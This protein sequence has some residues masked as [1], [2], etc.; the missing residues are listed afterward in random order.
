MGGGTSRSCASVIS[1]ESAERAIRIHP[2]RRPGRIGQVIHRATRPLDQ[3]AFAVKRLPVQRRFRVL[4]SGCIRGRCRRRPRH[5]RESRGVHQHHRVTPG[6]SGPTSR[7]RVHTARRLIRTTKRAN[8]DIHFLGHP[9]APRRVH[10]NRKCRRR[11]RP[12]TPHLDIA[13]QPTPAIIAR[14]N[15]AHTPHRI[16]ARRSIQRLPSALRVKRRDGRYLHV[17]PLFVGCTIRSFPNVSPLSVDSIMK[18]AASLP[19]CASADPDPHSRTPAPHPCQSPES[20]GR[21]R[22]WRRLQQVPLRRRARP[23]HAAVQQ[24]CAS[25]QHAQAAAWDP[26]SRGSAKSEPIHTTC[27]VPSL[28]MATRSPPL[29]HSS[30]RMLLRVHAHSRAKLR[31]TL[32]ARAILNVTRIEVLTHHAYQV[33]R[34][35]TVYHHRWLQTAF[36]HAHHRHLR[37]G[38]RCQRAHRRLRLHR[39]GLLWNHCRLC[40]NFNDRLSRGQSSQ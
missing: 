30:C 16:S 39:L 31:V 28:P 2:A 19:C 1:S 25:F 9:G 4:I 38:I 13:A 3:L 8:S 32:A 24:Q 29:H 10:R 33:H 40:R 5:Q 6:P 37:R 26:V 34:A 21:H 14:N 11:N 23:L 7:H 36:G 20:Q 27:T 12:C 22:R 18:I 35:M 17:A 15:A